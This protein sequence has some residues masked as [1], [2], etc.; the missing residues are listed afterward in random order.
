MD[1]L[2]KRF[3][4]AKAYINNPLSIIG[5][6]LVL[7]DGI[8]SFVIVN[9]HLTYSL[10][11]ILVLFIALFP[12]LVLITFFRLVTVHHKKLY[13][14]SD[15][16]DE[17]N[18]LRTFD[19]NSMTKV[20]VPSKQVSRSTESKASDDRVAELELMNNKLNDIVNVQKV[21]LDKIDGA[22]MNDVKELNQQVKLEIDKDF[23]RIIRKTRRAKVDSAF[24]DLNN[25]DDDLNEMDC[26]VS[27]SSELS[28]SR[29]FAN[30]LRKLGYSVE[31]W[32]AP[33]DLSLDEDNDDHSAIW[34]G[35]KVPLNVAKNVISLAYKEYPYLKYIHLSSDDKETVPPAYVHE[36]IF[37][38][39][40]TE[41]AKVRYKIREFN[42]DDFKKIN[43]CKSIRSLHNF[44]R[45]FYQK[46]LNH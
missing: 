26:Q 24:G 33:D 6:F 23:K 42:A 39:G 28:G 17:Q 18:F 35:T 44:I 8:A 30:R 5:L 36:Q 45:T 34:L 16:K 9:S 38:G 25:L 19:F 2:T 40:S 14:P 15:Y 32:N 29:N 10:N 13:S 21:L 43:D 46:V 37:I 41:T 1:S 22:H 11:L 3:D 27:I 20:E 12:I 31:V 4:K 7:V